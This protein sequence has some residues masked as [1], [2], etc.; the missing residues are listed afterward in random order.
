M[1]RCYLTG[2][3][4]L[5]S[6]IKKKLSENLPLD[7][8][9]IP[10]DQI[11]TFKY[12][13]F[14]YFFFCSTYGNLASHTDEE[15]IFQAN[16]EDLIHVLMQIKNF[17]F[18]S[19]VYV[20][21]SSVKLKTQTTYS[22]TKRAAE[23]ILLAYMERNKLP[24]CIIRPF[25]ITGVGEQ[26]EHLIPRLIKSCLYGDKI[27]FVG[28]PTHDFIDVEDVASGILNL[29]QNKA[30]GI[31]EL[32]TGKRYTNHD[33]LALVEAATG[34]SAK[35]NPVEGMRAYDNDNWVS[36]NFRAR[37]FGWLPTKSLQDSIREMVA[38]EKN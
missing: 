27:D 26:P 24:V 16:I 1:A 25:S 37:S 20:S 10:H 36:T 14:D 8:T 32:G 21:S 18:K 19:F 23:E 35:I 4:F 34:K 31:F 2:E 3:G 7:Y 12:A 13:P 6:N 33:V 11:Q 22:R 15:Q 38:Y 29:S 9:H 30:K 17:N 28:H 5:G